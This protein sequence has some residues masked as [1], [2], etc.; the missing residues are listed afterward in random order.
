M[1]GTITFCK[2]NKLLHLTAATDG[3][4]ECP[5]EPCDTSIP[6]IIVGT[7]ETKG[8]FFDCSIANKEFKPPSCIKAPTMRRMTETATQTMTKLKRKRDKGTS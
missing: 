8:R 3:T 1:G 7:F 4:L 5:E 6:K 2:L